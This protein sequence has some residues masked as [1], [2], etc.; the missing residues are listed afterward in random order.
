MRDVAVNS[1]SG[2][3]NC[4]VVTWVAIVNLDFVHH[5]DFLSFLLLSMETSAT[6]VRWRESCREKSYNAE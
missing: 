5:V 6:A 1:E 3:F 2:Q 4:E